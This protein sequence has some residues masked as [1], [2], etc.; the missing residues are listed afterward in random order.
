VVVGDSERGWIMSSNMM[1]ISLDQKRADPDFVRA[2]IAT[3]PNLRRQIRRYVNSAGR[4]VANA[5][6]MNLLQFPWPSIEEQKAIVA[7]IAAATEEVAA[8]QADAAKLRILKQ[9]LIADLLTGRVRVPA[10]IAS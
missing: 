9:G 6:I 10:E 4:D 8:Q 1:W 7:R 5:Q 3:N 2:N